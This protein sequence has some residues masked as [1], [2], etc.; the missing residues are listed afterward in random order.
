MNTQKILITGANGFIGKN[1]VIRLREEARF[2][3]LSFTRGDSLESL[4][5]LVSSADAI[6]HLAGE[7]RLDNEAD[8][9]RNVDLTD[10]LCSAIRDTGRDVPLLFASSIHAAGDTTYGR[11][12]REAETVIQRFVGDTLGSA[13]IFRLVGV[14]GKFCRPDYNSVVATFCHNIARGLPYQVSDPG[15]SV[16]LTYIDDVVEDI[17]SA[18][19]ACEPGLTWGQLR[20]TYS[21]TLGNLAEQ[22]RSFDNCR[23]SLITERVGKGL[24]RALYATYIS[25]LP[26]ERFVYELTPHKD[27]RGVF[28]EMLKTPDCG[29]FSFF[30]V[31]PGVT[32]GSHYHHS[33]TEK[34]LVVKGTTKMRFRHLITDE[35]HEVVLSSDA[36]QVMDTIPGW[37][38]D[39]TNIGN[40]EAIVMLWANEVFDQDKPDCVPCKV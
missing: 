10:F 18:L 28:V 7:N 4:R 39:I 32:R 21:I 33:K 6:V 37:V 40:S 35:L 15:V 5:N 11:S 3:V 1:L 31:L 17:L 38:H 29:Q 23:T 9:S 25:Y 14:F 2:D 19:N 13:V 22:I 27:G 30:T 8:F 24:T 16:E 20:Q 12:K 26:P 36:P 34:F